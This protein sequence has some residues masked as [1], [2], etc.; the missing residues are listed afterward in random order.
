MPARPGDASAA[1]CIFLKAPITIIIWGSDDAL[2]PDGL[3]IFDASDS[4]CLL[5]EDLVAAAEELAAEPGRRRL[6]MEWNIQKSSKECCLCRKQFGP[7]DSLFSAIFDHGQ[8][9]ERKDFCTPCWGNTHAQ[10]PV[11]SFWKTHVPTK[12][13]ERKLLVDDNV[14]LDFFMRLA[15]QQQAE[16]PEHKAKFRYILSLVLMRKKV[17]KF[18]DIIRED[19]KEYI[20]L[21]Y[22]KEKLDFKILDPGLTEEE[23]DSVKDDLAQILNVEV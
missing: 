18:V 2:P 4:G 21:R 23:A 15:E 5:L 1:F 11:F 16:Q 8:Q 9:F 3:V 12:E 7:G 22:P 20:T 17:L 10:Q 19:G 14:L 6:T 13:E